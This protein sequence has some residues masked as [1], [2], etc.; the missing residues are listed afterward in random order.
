MNNAIKI[1]LPVIISFI[2]GF[3][4][5]GPLSKFFIKYKLWKKH[6][7]TDSEMVSEEFKKVH[8]TEA[9]LGTPRVGGIIIWASVSITIAL[10]Y[11]FSILSHSP[12]AIKLNFLS[13]S[14]TVVPLAAFLLSAGLGLID[15]LAQVFGKGSYARDSISNRKTKV[16]LIIFISLLIS[17]WFVFKLGRT[18]IGVPFLGPIELGGIGFTLFFIITTLAVF[19]SSV[20]DGID[21]LAAGVLTPIFGAY[22]VIAYS[23]N[24]INLAAFCAVITGAI[25]VF[26]WFNVPPARFYMGETG[27]LALTVVLSVIA[28]LTDTVLVLPLIAFPLVMTSFSVV[29]QVLSY[30]YRNKKRVF[31]VTPLHH[32]FE[33]KGWT[34][35]CI[36]MRYWIISIVCSV[37]GTI[38][39]IISR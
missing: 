28:F 21:G 34:R 12:L 27:M 15:D 18:Y 36:T 37:L 20:I 29:V 31:L 30:K 9:E 35:P 26:L 6:A 5:T 10:F 1:L 39:V 38:I 25:L 33:A 17:L 22:T 2:V 11:I 23:N 7:R 19:S 32:H 14:Q 3:L 24:Q 8:N 13:K 16:G 4:I